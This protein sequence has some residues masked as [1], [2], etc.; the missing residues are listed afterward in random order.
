MLLIFVCMLA[1]VAAAPTYDRR[2]DGGFNVQADVSN[3]LFV[4]A[5]PKKIPM[6]LLSALLRNSKRSGEESIAQDRA[7]VSNSL[8]AFV[9]PNTPYRVIIGTEGEK[10]VEADG[11]D[12]IVIA[13]RRRL[14]A[15]PNEEMKLIGATEQC[16]PERTRDPVTLTCKSINDL[17]IAKP[18]STPEVIPVPT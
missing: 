10:V 3:I 5:L 1:A 17:R 15:E 2:Q 14:E 7:D 6:S 4:V 16:G 12:A 11:G 18:D 9:E 8:N 13:G